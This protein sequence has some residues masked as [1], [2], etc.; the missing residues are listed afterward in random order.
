MSDI[1]MDL[2]GLDS[3]LKAFKNPPTVR[4]GILGDNQ[5]N[6]TKGQ[7]AL[8]NAT[9][10]AFHE[11]GT[12]KLP[13]RSFLRMPLQKYLYKRLETAGI[14]SPENIKKIVK[15][16]SLFSSLQKVGI[17]AEGIIA[18]AFESGG[19]GEWKPSNMTNKQ[20]HQT[21]V[22]TQQLRDSITSE[23]VGGDNG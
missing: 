11:F 22:E 14:F 12:D 17:V 23:V 21:L 2:G 6:A 13:V 5:R 10:G 18:E 19:F 15:S 16:N 7:P 20:N 4:V 3:L 1:E 9:V 8:T